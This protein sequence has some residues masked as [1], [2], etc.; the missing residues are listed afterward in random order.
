MGGHP[1]QP[2][3]LAQ[4]GL[5]AGELAF[6]PLAGR[7]PETES[8]HKLPHIC[9]PKAGFRLRLLPCRS[10]IH[11]GTRRGLL[12][13][14]LSLNDKEHSLSKGIDYTLIRYSLIDPCN[15]ATLVSRDGRS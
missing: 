2:R 3:G 14:R 11:S 13:H 7:R 5:E 1:Q 6:H 8:A 15:T 9:G 12:E 4:E 10:C